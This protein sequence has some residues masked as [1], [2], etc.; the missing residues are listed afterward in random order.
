VR[1]GALDDEHVARMQQAAWEGALVASGLPLLG[2]DSQTGRP[3]FALAA[4]LAPATPGEAELA[5]IWLTDRRPRWQVREA[6]ARSTPD[7]FALVD[8]FDVWLGQAALPGQVVASVYRATT[9]VMGSHEA[10]SLRAAVIELVEAVALP[11][12]RL[13]GDRSVQYD[14][15]PF[16]D[17]IEAREHAGGHVEIGMT[18]RHDPEK[19]VGRP[20]EVLAELAE[21]SGVSLA[22]ATVVRERL[23]LASE[24]PTP[25]AGPRRRVPQRQGPRG[26]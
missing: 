14:L 20:D 26:R 13:R 1:R 24:R 21:R 12:Q 10:A 11:R 19:G 18:L 6:L 7:G 8:L 23:V 17:R 4:P 22:G 25:E 2:L 16:I 3:R 5:D 15:R 9:E